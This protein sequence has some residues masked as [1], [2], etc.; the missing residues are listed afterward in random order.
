MRWAGHKD[1][2]QRLER[3]LRF[4]FESQVEDFIA[5]GM[6]E[7]EARRAARLKFGGIDQIKDDCRDVRPLARWHDLLQGTRYAFRGFRRNPGFTA[8]AVL[9]LALAIG[10]NTAI[11]SVVD[12]V[13]LRALPYKD[14][15]RLAVIWTRN[16]FT[17]EG[18][19]SL[20][21]IDDWKQQSRTFAEIAFYLPPAHAS[22]SGPRAEGPDPENIWY[23]WVSSNFF[24]VLSSAPAAGR[25]FS[26]SELN[27]GERVA[28]IS[29]ELSQ[30]RFGSVPAAIGKTLDLNGVG[31][32]V[33]GVMTRQFHFP[34]RNN[35]LWLP[36]PAHSGLA[37][38]RANRG[39]A[40]AVAIGRLRPGAAV[41]QAHAEMSTIAASLRQQY[42]EPGPGLGVSVV[43]L[44][45]QLLG[46]TIP[47]MLL[48]LLGAVGCVLLIAC[49]NVANLL[50][51]RSVARQRE[52][53]IRMAIGAGR[54]R[55]I[56]QVLTESVVLSV[57]AGCLGLALAAWGIR[58]LAALGPQD[59]P[60][61]DEIGVDP[62]VLTFTAA[63]SVLAG[64][65]FGLA[66]AIRVSGRLA[67]SARVRPRGALV[68]AAFA[69][70]VMLL[71]GAGLLIRSFRAVMSVDPGFEAERVL[72]LR[73]TFRNPRMYPEAMA[74][75][76]E[77][78]GVAAVGA[79]NGVMFPV[80][81]GNSEGMRVW[82]ATAGDAFRALG[83]SLVRGRFFNERDELPDALPVVLVNETLA[84][85]TWLSEDPI[86]KQILG[87][88]NSM[89]VVGVVK[90]LRNQGI[91]RSPVMQAFLPPG[92][93][94]KPPAILVVRAAGEPAQ[95]IPAIRKT[96]RTLDPSA[97]LWNITTLADQI[98][99]QTSQRR[100]QSYLLGLFAAIAL[101]L[102][103]V[104]IY[105]LLHYSVAQRTRE[106][107]VRMALGARASDVVVM[108]VREGLV[109]ALSGVALGVAGALLLMRTI[110]SLLFGVAPNDPVTIA[111]ASGLLT[112]IA[113]VA[114]YIP[115]RRATRVDPLLAL[116][117][118]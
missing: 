99:E 62:A 61:L 60:R 24:P 113:L 20:S 90:D 92:P 9:T 26:K 111:A 80:S 97:V 36:I 8:V 115:A 48:V 1:P 37:A 42:P 71:T 23:S 4:H 2:E 56:R 101:V 74:R 77:I 12:G 49:S 50:L 52:I 100:F 94:S 5:A 19:T 16:S 110:A 31:F 11:F 85:R 118:E 59:I 88:A 43:P 40:S 81:P 105:G 109:L 33:I 6:S 87:N 32:Q 107:G 72:T 7:A 89:T 34:A 82:T 44:Q 83:V 75:L 64:I 70:A 67:Q 106:I 93:R 55:L 73:A 79:I 39:D 69:L 58:T 91:E 57:G 30:R 102:A 38:L 13:L 51:A 46:R 84:R 54:T 47:F 18:R 41:S 112:T 103:G 10:A 66:P 35:D 3:E 22:V 114:C 65:G 29:H 63:I 53:A 25:T 27:A 104:G 86:G 76:R 45:V 108:V 15:G 78:P 28:V 21:N 95:L 96:L 98:G 116:R 17:P 14:A 117:C 68:V